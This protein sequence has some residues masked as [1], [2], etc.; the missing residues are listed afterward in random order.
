MMVV[1]YVDPR[2]DPAHVLGLSNGEAAVIRN[3][4]G[5][6]T[7]ATLRT[8]TL[9]GKVGQANASTHVPGTWNLVILHHTDC[10]MTD[11]AP[12]PDLLAEYFEIP[13]DELAGKSVV[14]ANASVR[15][16]VEVILD[17]LHGSDFLV[18]GLVYDASSSGTERSVYGRHSST[19]P[20]RHRGCARIGNQNVPSRES[21]SGTRLIRPPACDWRDAVHTGLLSLCR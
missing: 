5:R 20:S 7:P 11:L 17:T 10:G 9:L 2:V 13:Q 4:G 12:Y 6:I 19:P 16:D 1:G 15:V 21:R 18:S 14:E 3:V 8:M